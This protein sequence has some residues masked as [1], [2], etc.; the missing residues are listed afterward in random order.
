MEKY[1]FLYPRVLPYLNRVSRMGG[2][3]GGG[4]I[5]GPTYLPPGTYLPTYP[6]YPPPPPLIQPAS[7]GVPKSHISKNFRLRR[8]IVFYV[9]LYSN[10]T[11]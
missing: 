4:Q 7:R 3:R 10:Y 8:R 6:P 11:I 1:L 5:L 2:G 9:L